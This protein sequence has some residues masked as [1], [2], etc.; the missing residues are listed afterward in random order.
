MLKHV[1]KLADTLK[2]SA[3]QWSNVQV[4]FNEVK[5]KS[6]ELGER[7]VDL[8]EKFHGKFRSGISEEEVAALSEQIKTNEVLTA[9][10]LHLYETIRGLGDAH[11]H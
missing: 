3:L 4:Y 5:G 8:E 6:K 11:H 9:E 2:P 10:Q 7:I 1:V